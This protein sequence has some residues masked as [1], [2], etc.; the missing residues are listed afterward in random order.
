M[1]GKRYDGHI[2]A[3]HHVGLTVMLRNHDMNQFR[4]GVFMAATLNHASVYA[5]NPERAARLLAAIVGGT[6][7]PF[8]ACEGGYVCFFDDRGWNGQYI[9]FYP[10]N[11][12]I[13]RR[14]GKTVIAKS[15]SIASG[16]GTHFNISVP[17]MAEQ[18]EAKVMA[19][20]LDCTWRHWGGF[21]DVWLESSLMLEL[22]PTAD[23]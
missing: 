1:F 2:A 10:K 14:D 3:V 13:A 20:G 22:L 8:P 16:A 12:T 15:D 9:E 6:T 5:D 18:L 21:L 7:M 17:L 11:V 19:L 4:Q 23:A